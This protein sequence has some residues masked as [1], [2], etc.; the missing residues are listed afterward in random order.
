M[1]QHIHSFVDTSSSSAAPEQTKSHAPLHNQCSSQEEPIHVALSSDNNYFEGL[2]VTA[3]TIVTNCSSNNLII[4]ILDGG[5]SKENWNFLKTTLPESRCIM[6]RIEIDQDAVLKNFPDYH[7]ASK[8]TFA[9]L[10]L[11]TLLPS[12]KHIIYSDVDIIWLADISVLRNLK[13][14]TDIMSVVTEHAFSEERNPTELEWF[15]C[16]GFNYS[17]ERYFCAGMI[18]FNLEKMR[19]EKLI[20]RISEILKANNWR[21]PNN[22]QTILNAL[23]FERNDVTILEQKWQTGTG[24]LPNTITSDIVIHYAAD[25][26]WKTIHAN[27]HMLTNAILFWHKVHAHIRSTSTWSSLRICNTAFD[28][29]AGRLLHIIAINCNLMRILLRLI[30]TLKGNAKGISC[31]N[32]FM[33]KTKFP[34]FNSHT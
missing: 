17:P 1:K 23:M 18:V 2:L 11:P 6:D 27:H 3:W 16:N 21:V 9:R 33:K 12:V 20:D 30:M 14:D 25:T 31:L 22:D 5:I 24:E 28:I 7:G 15:K 13:N 8:M 19:T 29:I 32:A 34:S 4:H 26:P 10:L